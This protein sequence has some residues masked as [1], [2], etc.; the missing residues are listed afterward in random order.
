MER[1]SYSSL[2]CLDEDVVDEEAFISFK[3]CTPSDTEDDEYVQLLVDREMSFGIKTN[4]SFLILN[5]VKLARLDAVA[6]I[7]RTRAVFGF[8]FRTAYLCVAYLDRFLSRRAID[9]DKTWAIRLLSVACLSLAAKMEECRAPALSEFAVEEYN[10]ESKVIQ[11]MELL[12][13]NTLE[14]RMGSITPFAFIHYFI[15]KF[16][17]QSP[18]PNVVSRTVQLTM[19]IM[20]EINLMDHRPS[21]IAAAAVLVAL[22]QRLTRNELESK[23]NAISSCGSLQPEDVFSCYSVVQGLDKEKR[24]LSLNPSTTQLRPAVDVHE[25]SSVTSAASTKRKRLTFYDCDPNYGTPNEKRPR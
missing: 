9:S 8:R 25:N 5:W 1:D 3:N 15:T 7:L 22:D 12:V 21:V 13:L 4:H 2:L 23:M 6:W 10:F 18:P 20:R 17:N 24:A 11:R 19:A 16:C 14:W